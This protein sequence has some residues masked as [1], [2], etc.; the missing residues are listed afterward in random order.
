MASSTA[1]AQSSLLHDSLHRPSLSFKA[2]P[3]LRWRIFWTFTP[4]L[5][6]CKLVPS[7]PTNALAR[8]LAHTGA[9]R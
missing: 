3:T 1:P 6:P 2:E 7:L 4:Y 8:R 5:T 9:S